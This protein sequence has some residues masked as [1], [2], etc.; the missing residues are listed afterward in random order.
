MIARLMQ[1]LLVV[2]AALAPLAA[3]PA[4]TRVP[5]PATEA[6]VAAAGADPLPALPA[7]PEVAVVAGETAGEG[8]FR[9]SWPR[10]LATMPA[11]VDR[12][13]LH[14]RDAA[15]KMPRPPVVLFRGQSDLRLVV[16]P[17]ARD[18][19][20]RAYGYL[21][22]RLIAA[23]EWQLL[24]W[25][26]NA[27]VRQVLELYKATG[28]SSDSV[29]FLMPRIDKVRPSRGYPGETEVSLEGV[30]FGLPGGNGG[31][32]VVPIGGDA[33]VAL[34]VTPLEWLDELDGTSSLR[35]RLPVDLPRGRLRLRVSARGMVPEIAAA[36]PEPGAP[37]NPWAGAIHVLGPQRAFLPSVGQDVQEARLAPVEDGWMLAYVDRN[38]SG[39]DTLYAARLYLGSPEAPDGLMMDG[40]VPLSTGGAAGRLDL[41][42]M[43]VAGGTATILLRSTSGVAEPGLDPASAL[44]IVRCAV[45]SDLTLQGETLVG[46]ARLATGSIDPVLVGSPDGLFLVAWLDTRDTGAKRPHPRIYGMPFGS[47]GQ[48]LATKP[49]PIQAINGSEQAASNWPTLSMAGAWVGPHLLIAWSQRT[50]LRP[51]AMV[52]LVELDRNGARLR[53]SASVPAEPVTFLPLG[54]EA[55]STEDIYGTANDQLID[56]VRLLAS[57]DGRNVLLLAGVPLKGSNSRELAF[58]ELNP[59]GSPRDLQRRRRL[60]TSDEPA[61]GSCLDA[62]VR[63][64]CGPGRR[65]DMTGTWNG[66]EFMT[67]WTF[68]QGTLRQIR[69]ARLDTTGRRPVE[70]PETRSGEERLDPLTNGTFAELN[71]VPRGADPRRA[72]LDVEDRP[73]VSSVGADT[74]LVWRHQF[75][76]GRRGLS[77]RVWR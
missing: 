55:L 2:A 69:G 24:D 25:R 33:T 53:P 51:S 48:P 10:R 21:G 37:G 3:V 65:E 47:S 61:G 28:E 45:T 68:V 27:R 20:C 73:E 8:V 74:L 15:G 13:E 67:A 64:P 30:H 50:D 46:A 76:G 54:R 59:D 14:F 41:A 52:Q 22:T 4:C 19:L 62:D 77:F 66:R 49:F 56:S 26:R 70:E 32:E 1:R 60:F 36:F 9:V 23:S 71:W 16:V 29:A 57:A 43:H 5:G 17:S 34:G 35:F 18:T 44:R 75:P 58:R 7:L 42:G 38:A 11:Q 63:F 40:P 12:L 6:F 31:L 39:N 72:S